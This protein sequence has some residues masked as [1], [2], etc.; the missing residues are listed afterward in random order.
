MAQQVDVLAV[1][2]QQLVT[3]QAL[4]VSDAYSAEQAPRLEAA[5][6]AVRELVAIAQRV[7]ELEGASFDSLFDKL[8]ALIADSRAA[9]APFAGAS[10]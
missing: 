3:H 8:D 2:D 10:K 6:A 9:L 1:L 4:A 7:A 5:I